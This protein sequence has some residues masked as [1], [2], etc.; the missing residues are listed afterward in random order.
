MSK[1]ELEGVSNVEAS[2]AIVDVVRLM[3][4]KGDEEEGVPARLVAHV[5]IND[6]GRQSTCF[7][8]VDAPAPPCVHNFPELPGAQ[9][10]A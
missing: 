3:S 10:N 2:G 5:Q 1:T 8:Q 7:G 4:F 9:W 6:G